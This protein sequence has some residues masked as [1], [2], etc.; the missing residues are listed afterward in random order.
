MLVSWLEA[1]YQ[2]AEAGIPVVLYE[3]KPDKYSPAHKIPYFAELVCSNSLRSNL[4]E[5]AVGVLK[6]ELRYQIL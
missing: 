2:I 6:Q 1:A 5:N 4:L 3:M